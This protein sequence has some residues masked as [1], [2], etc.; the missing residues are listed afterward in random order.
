MLREAILLV[1]VSFTI[2]SCQMANK[3][4]NADTSAVPKQQN[5]AVQEEVMTSKLE[6]SFKKDMA[7]ADLRK[8]VLSEGWAPMP[9]AECKKNVGGEALVCAKLPELES[10]SGDG[11]CISHFVSS[12]GERL[13]VTSYGMSEDWNVPGEESRFNVIEW[14]FAK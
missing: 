2:T 6:A 12:S 1:L 14:S 4:S 11:Y 8:V 7:Y 3:S 13:D 5:A 10:C 9:T